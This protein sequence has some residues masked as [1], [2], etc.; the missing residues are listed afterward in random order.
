MLLWLVLIL[1]LAVASSAPDSDLTPMVEKYRPRYTL[2]AESKNKDSDDKLEPEKALGPQQPWR[3][4]S[5]FGHNSPWPL[6][7]LVAL[8]T[9]TILAP[10]L[11]PGLLLVGINL[12]ALLY[13]LLSLLGLS[14]N[15]NLN[16]FYRQNLVEG[17]G[18][19]SDVYL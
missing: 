13:M 15:R 2:M 18:K 11:G 4:L 9:A 1:G 6:N 16:D 10:L 14:P 17:N 19:E 7:G 12:G 3:R 5:S 8:P